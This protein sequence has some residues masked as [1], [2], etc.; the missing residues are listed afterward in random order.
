[1]QEAISAI[2]DSYGLDHLHLTVVEEY[3]RKLIINDRVVRYLEQHRP[4]PLIELHARRL[5]ARKEPNRKAR[6]PTCIA[7]TLVTTNTFA[8]SGP[9]L[10]SLAAVD[11]SSPP[12]AQRN[13]DA[14]HQGLRPETIETEHHLSSGA[15]D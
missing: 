14:C 7:A 4:E 3:L 2:H 11:L 12:E 6:G 5:K 8:A 10:I 1:L 9:M 15:R 13:C